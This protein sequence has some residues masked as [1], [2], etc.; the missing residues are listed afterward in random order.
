MSS[1]LVQQG[2]QLNTVHKALHTISPNLMS[3]KSI[4]INYLGF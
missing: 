2:F 1:A 3:S 4:K